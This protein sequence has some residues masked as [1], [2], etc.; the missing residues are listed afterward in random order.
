[1]FI[2][3]KFGML[4]RK[5]NRNIY[6]EASYVAPVKVPCAIVGN[7]LKVQKTPVRADSSADRGASEETVIVAKILFPA[8]VQIG[9][10][11]KFEIEG[12]A[13]RAVTIEKRFAVI[14]GRLDHLEVDFGVW[15]G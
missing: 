15:V 6:G 14:G 9:E 11:D 4:S 8:S 2:P 3:N 12:L 7:S 1:M 13:L 10:G 5:G